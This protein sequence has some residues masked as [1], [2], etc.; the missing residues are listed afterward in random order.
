M[1]GESQLMKVVFCPAHGCYVV[2][3]N[4][5]TNVENTSLHFLHKTHFVLVFNGLSFLALVSLT[6]VSLC[7]RD[8]FLK[9]LSLKFIELLEIFAINYENYWCYSYSTGSFASCI[10]SISSMIIFSVCL[11][12]TF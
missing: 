9:L 10:F 7:G 12:L 8:T 4:L 11:S 1:E 6:N 5:I 2:G 3:H